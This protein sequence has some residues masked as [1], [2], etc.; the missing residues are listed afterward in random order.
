[1]EDVI[2]RANPPSLREEGVAEVLMQ[3]RREMSE[4]D[5]GGPV[6]QRGVRALCLIPAGVEVTNQNARA[7]SAGEVRGDGGGEVV[8]EERGGVSEE[9]GVL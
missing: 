5:G 8:Q 2:D 6:F 4:G 9:V 3:G 7:A 1:M